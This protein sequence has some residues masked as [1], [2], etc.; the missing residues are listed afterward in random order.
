MHAW[1]AAV[2]PGVMLLVTAEGLGPPAHTQLLKQ[3]PC[4]AALFD[5]VWFDPPLAQLCVLLQNKCSSLQANALLEGLARAL[6]SHAW[7][8]IG[9]RRRS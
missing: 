4:L 6:D 7:S 1:G 8:H 5:P 3:A 2:Y 9:A